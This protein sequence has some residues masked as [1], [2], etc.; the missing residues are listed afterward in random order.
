MQLR[1]KVTCLLIALNALQSVLNHG[2]VV[3]YSTRPGSCRTGNPTSG[4]H[5]EGDRFGSMEYAGYQVVLSNRTAFSDEVNLSTGVL[6]DMD[7][8]AT[9]EKFKYFRGLLIRLSSVDGIDA[10]HVLSVPFE[11]YQIGKLPSTGEKEGLNSA[12]DEY[13]S[14]LGHNAPVKKNRILFNMEFDVAG[15]YLMEVTVVHENRDSNKDGYYISNF[16]L[17]VTQ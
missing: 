8:R 1:S 3:A 16:D 7:I 11:E 15:T 12:C 2:N 14:G 5:Q 17:Y 6:Y 9:E 4:S 10:S 13:V